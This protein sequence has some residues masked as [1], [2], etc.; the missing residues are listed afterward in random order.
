MGRRKDLT[1][2]ERYQIEILLKDKKSISE[3]A[4]ILNRHYQTIYREIKKGMVELVDSDLKLYKQYCADRGQMIA[5]AN[6][7]E[8]GRELKI[9]NDM[10]FVRF[11][12][13]MILEERY[14][15]AAILA[16]IK[17]NNLEYKTDVCYTTLYSYIDKGLFLN[18]TN[19]HLPIKGKRKK[20]NMKHITRIN[21]KNL[22]GRSIEKRAEEILERA[23]YGHWEMDT[24]VG[25]QGGDKD[26]LLVLTERKTRYEYI[27]KMPDKTQASV[28]KALDDLE[29]FYGF[30]GFKNTFKTI[31]MDN[32]VEFLNMEGV[33]ASVIESNDKRTVAYYCHPY[34]SFER[35]SNE[36]QNK[37]V[38]RW[39]AKGEDISNYDDDYIA[40]MQDWINAYPR[41]LFDWQS[42]ADRLQEETA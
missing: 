26:C 23:D 35:G 28:I 20:K 37:L 5:D 22:K 32:G 24:V 6:K 18:V 2:Y 41:K 19:K 36:N 8:K 21:T 15:P 27:I 39:I 25:K 3:I 17:N 31:T 33:E 13:R 11:V 29:R 14:S 4:V 40:K 12:E 9:A 10:E 1:E 34:C 42:A 7:H 30:E 38:R 16:Y